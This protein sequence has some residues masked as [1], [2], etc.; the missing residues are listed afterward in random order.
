MPTDSYFSRETL[1][2]AATR[3]LTGCPVLEIKEFGT[4]NINRTFLVTQGFHEKKPFLLQRLNTKVFQNPDLVLANICS[5]TRH[6]R[7]QLESNRLVSDRR[8][9][10][11]DFLPTTDGKD[12]WC[13]SDGSFWRAMSFIENSH[14]KD[15]ITG[16]DHAREVGFA[17]GT[18]HTLLSDL[19]ISQLADTLPGFHITPTY[20]ERYDEVLGA[21]ASKPSSQEEWCLRFVEEHRCWAPLLQN[22]IRQGSLELRPIHGD[23]KINNILIDD[24]TGLAL[25]MIDLDTVK[26]GLIQ[27]DI[28]DCLRSCCN[29]LGEEPRDWE[30]VVFDPEIGR[31]VLVGYCQIARRFLTPADFDFLPD[32][33]RL[34]AF[35]LGLRFFM[36]HLDGN[37][38]F[39]A[40]YRGHNLFRALVQF[41]LAESID[42]QID[43]IRAIV[44][45][46]R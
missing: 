24:L 10:I 20:L 41:R 25:S 26:P 4:G 46:L 5:V 37:S 43:E 17:L 15:I 16:P 2:N 36:D 3:F 34:I 21:L 18:F 40:A 35:E 11:P 30:K 27:F 13:S 7:K 33:I 39:K 38:Y 1:E 32:A 9:E 31:E 22:A 19:P 44:D 42:S 14:V 45:D 29:A 28:G 6:V 23:P 8:W 12:H